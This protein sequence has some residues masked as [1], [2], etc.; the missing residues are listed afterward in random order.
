MSRFVMPRILWPPILMLLVLVVVGSTSADVEWSIH[1]TGITPGLAISDVVAT[2]DGVYLATSS[3]GSSPGLW[4]WT[5]VTG[6]QAQILADDQ[7]YGF[8]RIVTNGTLWVAETVVGPPFPGR[9]GI[10]EPDRLPLSRDG[11]E[12]TLGPFG[13]RW[14]A[15]SAGDWIIAIDQPPHREAPVQTTINGIDW[16]E[17]PPLPVD[18]ERMSTPW[19]VVA[20]WPE[21]DTFALATG[22]GVIRRAEGAT[23]T[24]DERTGLRDALERWL[25]GHVVGTVARAD[26]LAEVILT[27]ARRATGRNELLRASRRDDDHWEIAVLPTEANVGFPRWATVTAAG[28]VIAAWRDGAVRRLDLAGTWE[29]QVFP[30]EVA[31]AAT[32]RTR[33]TASGGRLWLHGIDTFLASVELAALE[34]IREHPFFPGT[35]F[36]PDGYA[37]TLFGPT[38]IADW[39]WIYTA[40]HGW[41]YVEPVEIQTAT[42]PFAPPT[43]PPPFWAW[44][45]S[46]ALNWIYTAPH[47]YPLVFS[48][49]RYGW[50]W[51]GD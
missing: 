48:T 26:G 24:W 45:G 39:P 31:A 49:T 34:P 18:P 43:E 47:L 40:R 37:E 19:P 44:D 38:W 16:T 32:N 36:A 4:H 9:P 12:W 10:P 25:P 11:T 2:D 30:L 1:D 28:T 46:G 21:G 6:G 23:F 22:D 8:E 17:W 7:R 14:R 33:F 20:A 3:Y 15:W 35:T 5:G 13:T 50:V 27:A 41:W 51:L 29:Q 42:D